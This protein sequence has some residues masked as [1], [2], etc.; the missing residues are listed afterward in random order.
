[1]DAR[2][3]AAAVAE[4]LAAAG[5]RTV[6][7]IPGGGNNLEL[8]GA[9]EA[10]G[11][12]FVLAHTETAAA[13]MA[14]VYGELTGTP[15]GCLAT[16]GPGAANA[17]NGVAQAWLDRQPLV[18]L[19]DAV[20]AADT[21]R[22][23][24]Q[25]IDQP[26]MFAPITK[27][28]GAVGGTADPAAVVKRVVGLTLAGRPGPVHIDLDPAVSTAA[29]E[30]EHADGSPHT[31]DLA[32]VA[33]LVR[34]ARRPVIIAG[35]GAREA[36]AEVRELVRGTN[37]PVLATYKAAGVVPGSGPNAAGLLTGA[38]VEAPVL[39]AA[40]LIIAVGLDTVELIPAPWRYVAPVVA[41]AAWPEE[42]PYFTPAHEVVG[43]L[44][45]LLGA[46][47]GLNDDWDPGFAR[48]QRDACLERLAAGPEAQGGLAPWEVVAA[49][50]AIAPAGSIATVDSGAHML[51]AMPQWG[52]DEPGEVLISSGLA[53]MGFALPAAIAAGLA[54]PE[55]RTFCFVGDGGLGM[56]LAELETLTRLN[57]P[58]TV[59][60]FNDSALSLIKVKQRGEGHGGDGAIAYGPVD[61]AALAAAHG[62]PATIADTPGALADAAKASLATPGP[63]LID[64]RVDPTGYPHVL[65]V[66]RG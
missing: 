56:V 63:M 6:F 46:L 35:L 10:A 11:L 22:I 57:L 27:W 28:S 24:H 20:S 61:Y 49:V 52:A 15:T 31:G 47:P 41:L 34:R 65:G 59:V 5:S 14:A 32:A 55:R 30:P 12:R 38:T 4:E 23:G 33:E 17:V 26:A 54:R 8:I 42:S 19:T 7:G 58:V 53:T 13:Y 40:D 44:P 1:M 2:G 48:A 43:P 37:V 3:L 29:G 18:M 62:L 16:R 36:A 66:I 9:A 45:E 39:E 60:V 64:A 51:A 50:R 25:R 21:P